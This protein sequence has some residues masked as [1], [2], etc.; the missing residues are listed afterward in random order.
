MGAI[1]SDIDRYVRLK[2][3]NNETI[4]LVL[5]ASCNALGIAAVIFHPVS[6]NVFVLAIG[7]RRPEVIFRGNIYLVLS[8]GVE[9]LTTSELGK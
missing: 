1:L 5:A 8:E 9:E 7:P 2:E 4:D 6:S 3:Y